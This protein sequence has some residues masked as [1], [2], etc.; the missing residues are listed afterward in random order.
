MATGVLLARTLG[1]KGSGVLSVLVAF[2]TTLE[3]MGNLGQPT[4]NIYFMGK[5][6]DEI[7]AIAGNAIVLPF[8]LS[9]AIALLIASFR[10][11]L[12]ITFLDNAD[13]LLILIV[14]WLLPFWFLEDN[15]YS[16]LRGRRSEERRVGKEC[17]L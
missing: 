15:L 6:K 11:F 4:A 8:F 3:N 9:G 16:L 2:L 14:L 12:S 13:P 7:P 17:R 5:R 1:A 10:H